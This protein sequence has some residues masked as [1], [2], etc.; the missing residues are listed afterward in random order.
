M[1]Y[2]RINWQNEPSEATALNDVNL[3]A[4]DSA[5]YDHDQRLDTDEASLANKVDKVT[6]KGLSQVDNLVITPNTNSGTKVATIRKDYVDG[7]LMN[8]EV[9]NGVVVDSALSDSSTN[10]VQNK[11]VKGALDDKVDKVTGK[12]LT[13]YNELSYVQQD[14]GTEGD[15]LGYIKGVGFDGTIYNL[16]RIKNGVTVDSALSSSSENPVQN[17]V[18]KNALD[19]KSA[20]S[21]SDTLADG[22]TIANITIDGVTTPIKATRDLGLSVVSG[23]LNIT[24]EE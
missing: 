13:L 15:N 17:K 7:S 21:I 22:D 18:V 1:S 9:Y 4:M 24:W 5:I 6:G 19:A 23:K 2:T 8:Y 11:V 10:P 14:K 3:N 12:G 20:V 16:G